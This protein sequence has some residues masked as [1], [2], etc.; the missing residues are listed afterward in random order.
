M[1]SHSDQKDFLCTMCGKQFKRK[2][3]L[4]M[5]MNKIHFT[6]K[7]QTKIEKELEDRATK[8]ENKMK[9]VN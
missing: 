6:K 7:K 8:L 5:H 9:M 4:K 2:D 1:Y 3:K